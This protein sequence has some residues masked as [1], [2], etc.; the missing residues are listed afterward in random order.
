ML[1][2][3]V[4][5]GQ[6]E[7]TYTNFEN[8]DNKYQG[9][10]DYLKWL[11]FGYARTSDHASMEIRKKRKTREEGLELVKKFLKKLKTRWKVELAGKGSEKMLRRHALTNYCRV[12]FNASEFHYVD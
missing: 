12:L 5:D 1:F 9:V 2:R 8:L 3:S 6:S 10:H 4:L 11:K 7:G